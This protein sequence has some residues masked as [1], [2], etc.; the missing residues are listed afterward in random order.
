M[1]QSIYNGNDVGK[2]THGVCLTEAWSHVRSKSSW[3]THT[4]PNPFGAL[5][6]GTLDES[7]QRRLWILYKTQTWD[8]DINLTFVSKLAP[9]PWEWIEWEWTPCGSVKFRIRL[10]DRVYWTNFGRISSKSVGFPRLDLR[11][12]AQPNCEFGGEP[13]Q[14]MFTEPHRGS[15]LM[16]LLLQS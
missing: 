7:I 8:T 4:H 13:P 16:V 1:W 12:K 3:G 15:V 10:K 14:I 5:F 2:M 6:E 11:R 9:T